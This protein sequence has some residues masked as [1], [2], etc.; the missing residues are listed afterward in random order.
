MKKILLLVLVGAIALIV[1]Y[2][3]RIYVRDP[4]A[5]V[6]RNDVKPSGVEV[7]VSVS[8]DV[9]LWQDAESGEYRTLLQGWNKMPGIPY[10]LTC[11]RWLVCLTDADHAS[12]IPLNW[13]DNSGKGRGN[14][15]PAV[16]MTGR[17]ITY[18]DAD[19]ETM[20]VVL[21]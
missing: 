7:F 20:R 5:T 16:T 2:R 12:I 19:G 4:L 13:N 17:E 14:Y 1:L 6:T 11:L 10:R 15:D 3:Q 9:L 21:R 18:M 8:D